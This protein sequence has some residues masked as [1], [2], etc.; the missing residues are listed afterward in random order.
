MCELRNKIVV[1]FMACFVLLGYSSANAQAKKEKINFLFIAIDDMNDWTGFLGGHPQASTPNLDKLADKGTNF[2]NAHCSAPGCS[3]SRNALLY[4]IEPFN[5]GLYPFYDEGV[6]DKIKDKYTSIPQLLKENGYTT[7]GAGKIHHGRIGDPIEWTDFLDRSNTKVKKVFAE[8]EGYQVGNKSKMSFRPTIQSEEENVDYKVAS[9]GVDFLKEKHEEPFFLAI[10]IVKPHLPFDAPKRFFDA[11]PKEITPPEIMKS[12]LNDIPSAGLKMRKAGDNNKFT[13]EKKWNDVRRAYLACISWADYNI[14]RV[15]EALEE[16]EYAD[17]T[18][19]IVWSDHGYH[20]GEKMAFKKFTL[21]ERA[22]KVPFII[23]DPRIK[24]KDQIDEAISL[25]NVYKTISEMAGIDAPDYVDGQSL[26]PVISKKKSK[27]KF[28]YP[29]VTSWGKGNYA[30]RSKDY[31]LIRYY[32]GSEELYAHDRDS[33]EWN[34]VADN[35]EF[36]SVKEE[37]MNYLPKSEAPMITDFINPWSV[38]GVHLK[39]YRSKENK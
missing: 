13:K 6:H 38:E 25:I 31:R 3:P 19:V 23:Y 28:D 15:L 36:A 8:G 22:T 29:V 18:V 1:A 5:S 9:Y 27:E 14:G 32:D 12:D 21:W 20:L 39:E 35:E 33:N 26:L 2:T 7:H 11:L 37:L 34:N 10:G 17:N 16:S 24:Q 4:G 30:V